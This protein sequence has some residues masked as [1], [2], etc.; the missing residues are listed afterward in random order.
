MSLKKKPGKK[1]PLH[2]VSTTKEEDALVASI[3]A[4]D[5]SDPGKFASAVPDLAIARAVAE[6]LCL[7]AEPSITL[8]TVLKDR[9]KDK[10]IN[11]TLKRALFKL[12]QKGVIVNEAILAEDSPFFDIRPR[13]E[14]KPEAF[15]GP[16]LNMFGSRAVYITHFRGVRGLHA[17]MGLVSDEDGIHDFFYGP[18][19][20][21]RLLEAKEMVS[22]N[23]GPLVETSLSHAASIF[24][25]AY[26]RH[27]EINKREHLGFSELRPWYLQNAPPLDHSAIYDY[28]PEQQSPGRPLTDSQLERLL[29]Q[30][31][32][33]SWVIDFESLKPYLEE[34]IKLDESPIILT[35]LQ[36]SDQARRLKDDCIEKLFSDTSRALLKRR[37][38]EMAYFF[39][40]Q[41]QEDLCHLCL[42]AG[43]GLINEDSHGMKNQVLFYLV[44]RSFTLYLDLAEGGK[45]ENEFTPEEPTSNIIF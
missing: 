18:I 23:A 34:L 29:N 9:F 17:G 11:K 35:E 41:G 20:K 4:G 3:L 10:Q 2:T 22:E 1:K 31:P 19:G 26:Q 13:Q 25:T 33:E 32:M 42:G 27:L 5:T 40:K 8:L 6:R 37:F 28:V 14:D 16:I 15:V 43:Q 30:G 24:E 21:K 7:E 39:F 45:T 44:N 12:R 36:K 38:E